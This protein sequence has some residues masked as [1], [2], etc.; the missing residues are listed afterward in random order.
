MNDKAKYLAF[1]RTLAEVSYG[2][3]RRKETKPAKPAR[4][5][6][7]VS[8]ETDGVFLEAAEDEGEDG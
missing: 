3:F 2:E 7:E 1:L 8:E 4:C 6:D 5:G